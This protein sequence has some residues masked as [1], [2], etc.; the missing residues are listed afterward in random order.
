MDLALG[1]LFKFWLATVFSEGKVITYSIC[2]Y[3]LSR[4]AVDWFMGIQIDFLGLNC[5]A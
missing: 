2:W 4:F 1:F 3:H 5:N